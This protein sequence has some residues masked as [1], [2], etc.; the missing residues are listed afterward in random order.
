M[1]TLA[2]TLDSDNATSASVPE[3]LR[4]IQARLS[5]LTANTAEAREALLSSAPDDVYENE[6]AGTC[7]VCKS[8]LTR[9][10][11][12]LADQ[13][14]HIY[15]SAADGRT[16][17]LLAADRSDSGAHGAC[18]LTGADHENPDDCTTHDHET[19]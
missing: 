8:E 15:C 7:A 6:I 11:G 19:A 5:L 17:H 3:H 9:E 12:F 2:Y 14:G 4:A 13:K 18:I 10:H 16:A 1:Y